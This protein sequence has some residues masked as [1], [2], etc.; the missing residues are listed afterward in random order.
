[1]KATVTI[2]F[3]V[4]E[5]YEFTGEVRC[6]CT[7]DYYL[8]GAWTSRSVC[9]R[10]SDFDFDYEKHPILRK[11]EGW[12]P[13]TPEKVLELFTKQSKVKL[14][15]AAS[16]APLVN[17][18]IQDIYYSTCDYSACDYLCLRARVS[19][20]IMDKQFLPKEIEYLEESK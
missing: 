10:R 2:E 12:K 7:G 16:K 18:R 11:A 13:L 6:P 3:E 4:P 8:H 14:R 19:G 1:M 20:E 17:D 9:V 15:R 5:G